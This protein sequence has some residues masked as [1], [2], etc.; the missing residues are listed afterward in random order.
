MSRSP[1]RYSAPV[2]ATDLVNA[3]LAR[4]EITF[5]AVVFCDPAISLAAESTSSSMSRVVRMHQMIM[6]LMCRYNGPLHVPQARF[7]AK[8]GFQKFLDQ[9]GRDDSAPARQL[10]EAVA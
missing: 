7:R 3:F 6:H 2:L 8:L 4:S 1:L 10:V 9:F 5:P